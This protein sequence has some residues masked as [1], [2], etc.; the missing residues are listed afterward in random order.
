MRLEP[1]YVVC[2]ATVTTAKGTFTGV[3]VATLKVDS[4]IGDAR[5]SLSETRAVAGACGHA[6]YVMDSCGAEELCFTEMEPD[7]EQTEE[8]PSVKAK[9]SLS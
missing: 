6:G 3:G 9:L 2:P 5:A 8:D 1:D 4:R 7:R